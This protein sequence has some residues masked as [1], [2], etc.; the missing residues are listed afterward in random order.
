MRPLIAL[1]CLL[2]LIVP[3]SADEVPISP[4]AEGSATATPAFPAEPTVTVVPSGTF[5]IAP[6]SLSGIACT[7][8]A[9]PAG[10]CTIAWTMPL[11]PA[12][13]SGSFSAPTGSPTDYGPTT[14]GFYTA[15]CTATDALSRTGV[16]A[17]PMF[18]VLPQKPT[19]AVTDDPSN[20][21]APADLSG[22]TCTVNSCDG[23]GCTIAW[24]MPTAPAGDSGSFS[25]PTGSPTNYG[26]TTT[27][28]Y[29]A[30]CTATDAFSSTGSADTASMTVA[31][32]PPSSAL[33][34]AIN[35]LSPPD[36]LDHVAPWGRRYE[37][38]STATFNGTP[39]NADKDHLLSCIWDFDVGASHPAWAQ[40][41]SLASGTMPRDQWWP[42]PIAGMVWETPGVKT[43]KATCYY[44]DPA[45]GI[46]SATATTTETIVDPDV[47]YA[48]TLT[49]CVSASGTFQSDGC[50]AG[51]S[52]VTSSVFNIAALTPGSRVLYHRGETYTGG[53]G[54]TTKG[55][56]GNRPETI[57]A[58]GTGAAPIWSMTGNGHAITPLAPG[59][60]DRI[61]DLELQNANVA[62]NPDRGIASG[63][64]DQNSDHFYVGHVLFD[65]W[66][67]DV[68][69]SIP[70]I[71]GVIDRDWFVWDTVQLSE[72]SYDFGQVSWFQT[73]DGAWMVGNDF[74]TEINGEYVMRLQGVKS[75]VLALNH[76][77]QSRE[78]KGVLTMRGCSWKVACGCAAGE[79]GCSNPATG[80]VDSG[81]TIIPWTSHHNAVVYN[82]MAQGPVNARVFQVSAQ[83][84]SA[85]EAHDIY[86][87]I[88]N[89][90]RR[91]GQDPTN[92][93]IAQFG[94]L[95]D[96]LLFGN[97]FDCR[98]NPSGIKCRGASGNANDFNPDERLDLRHG[99][100][101]WS[102]ASGKTDITDSAFM[103]EDSG[104][105]NRGNLQYSSNTSYGTFP[106]PCDDCANRDV[107]PFISALPTVPKITDLAVSVGS[108]LRDT[109]V[110]KDVWSFILPT[111][112]CRDFAGNVD[113]GPMDTDLVACPNDP[114]D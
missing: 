76:F 26:P 36:T 52:H 30:R 22:L 86:W 87:I 19:V 29:V 93:F 31:S 24:T 5:P 81:T 82:D 39:I 97:L 67:E 95:R 2:V 83:K 35:P 44:D 108:L 27:G 25:A 34:F 100:A 45:T 9:C 62:Q 90:L 37:T 69:S 47:E 88:G 20:P 32:T 109:V 1:A 63:T 104:S 50:P 113:P 85:R 74:G 96:A 75:T 91:S 114:R 21:V 43:I 46:V 23:G 77:G 15:K 11:V 106:T 72:A 71:S 105:V 64:T 54:F 16:D 49:T 3:A 38:Y 4:N 66:E 53:K 40:Q 58:Y 107:E 48:N 55:P 17:A 98:N 112:E 79:T 65:G 110:G 70:D 14:P 99:V 7:V 51:A 8:D 41:G 10:G 78:K 42:T 73:I 60:G 102:G 59:F 28:S 94:S 68:D 57:G 92:N 89:V 103:F 18:V 6:N 84:T 33:Q 101:Y 12:G 61:L 13:D 56:S 80:A 111:G